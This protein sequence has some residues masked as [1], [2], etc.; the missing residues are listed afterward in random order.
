M[1]D[2]T[3]LD[4]KSGDAETLGLLNEGGHHH[5]VGA[6]RLHK[7]KEISKLISDVSY[8]YL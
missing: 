5:S 7:M 3:H 2:H 1:N 4:K 8:H 6:E